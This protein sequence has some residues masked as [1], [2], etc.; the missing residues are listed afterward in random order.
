MIRLSHFPRFPAFSHFP[1]FPAFPRFPAFRPF[2]AFLPI[3]L[4][5]L[6]AACTRAEDPA[7][8]VDLFNSRDLAGWEFVSPTATAIVTVCTVQPDGVL[9]VAGKPVGYLVTTGSFENYRLHVEYC[10]PADAAPNS[11]SGILV[12]IATGPIDRGTWPRCVQVQT[13]V[14]RAGDLLPMAG[15]KFAEPLSTAPDARTPQLDRRNA[16][17]EKPLGEWNTVE[18]VCRGGALEVS[19]NGVLQNKVTGC[20]PGAGRIGIQCEGVP[21]KLRNLRLTPLE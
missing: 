2:P 15:A 19:V 7:K 17:S 8:T 20:V 5:A 14:T 11:N 12:H 9:A 21:F 1:A 3:A 6:T 16:S 18:V 10:W 13:K 4:L